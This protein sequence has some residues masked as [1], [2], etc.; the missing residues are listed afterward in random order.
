MNKDY[1][2]EAYFHK[3]KDDKIKNRINSVDEAKFF[4]REFNINIKQET[5]NED[6]LI[7]TL[8]NDDD[9]IFQVFKKFYGE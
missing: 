3:F 6:I 9:G 7:G 4:R 2:A 1:Y 8:E 5:F